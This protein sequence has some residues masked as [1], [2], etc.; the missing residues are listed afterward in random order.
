MGDDLVGLPDDATLAQLLDAFRDAGYWATA[1]DPQWRA[2]YVT[3][4]GQRVGAGGLLIGEFFYS[5]AQIEARLGYGAAVNTI[6]AMRDSLRTLG[7]LLLA[8]IDGGR[9]AL[10]AM[11]HPELRDLVDEI[12]PCERE[13][14]YYEV[15]ASAFGG[16]VDLG[17]VAQRVRDPSGRLVGTVFLLAPTVG[18]ATL[19]MLAGVGDPEHFRRMQEFARPDRHAAAVLFADLEG[20]TPL[21]KQLPTANYFALVRRLTRAVDRCVTEASGL[22]GRH[23][24]DGVTAF[25]AAESNGSESAAAR[26][27]ISTA[28]AVQKAC[29]EVA[30]QHGLEQGQLTMRAGLHW[31][32]TLYI[33]SI[34]TSG[35]SEVTALGDEVND[36]ARIEA[37]AAGGRALASKSLIERLDAADAAALGIDPQLLSY[38]QLADLDTATDKA[39]RDAPSIAVADL[40]IGML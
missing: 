40:A 7:G 24:G 21:A 38:M 37:C 10:R 18:M 19:F 36:A 26:A 27:C 31:G 5:T 35:R 33:G 34:T 14:L 16:A 13:A 6:E 23:V 12:E 28:R 39:R 11:V 22:V 9:D 29:A 1:V 32:T 30:A 4:E 2:I 17:C 3:D 25:F 15:P 20:S 8:D